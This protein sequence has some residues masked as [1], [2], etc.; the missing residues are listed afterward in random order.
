MGLLKTFRKVFGNDGTP[1]DRIE[2]TPPP[3][4]EPIERR[5]RQRIDARRGTRILVIDDSKT[6]LAVF[7]KYFAAMGYVVHEALDAESGL[8]LA[9]DQVPQL[10]F[11]DII[12][13]GMDGFAA[14]RQIRRD[15]ATRDIPVIL[16]SGN[17]HA[18]GQF[19]ASRIGADDFMKKPFTRQDAFQRIEGLLDDRLIP[20]HTRRPLPGMDATQTSSRP[21]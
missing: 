10:I 3:A 18:A 4:R 7:T 13:P 16:I 19:Y 20:R 8:E 6:V 5:R 2:V 1:S 9:R 12:L 11:R 15:P 21:N 14:L 17:E